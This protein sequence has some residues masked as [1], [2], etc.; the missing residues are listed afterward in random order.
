MIKSKN[1][2]GVTDIVLMLGIIICIATL[3]IGSYALITTY[4]ERQAKASQEYLAKDLVSIINT[5]QAAPESATWEYYT[6]RDVNGYPVIGSLEIDEANSELC[7]HPKSESE[8]FGSIVD[9]ASK[10]AGLGA[11]GYMYSKV[12]KA[13]LDRAD[14]RMLAQ[15][16]EIG[17]MFDRARPETEVLPGGP[18]GGADIFSELKTTPDGQRALW[19]LGDE[20][21]RGDA[22]RY[23]LITKEKNVG[24]KAMYFGDYGT[25]I[26]YMAKTPNGRS[27][28]RA[29]MKEAVSEMSDVEF[30]ESLIKKGRVPYPYEGY[31]IA[32]FGAGVE[33][34]SEDALKLLDEGRA[35]R[36]MFDELEGGSLKGVGKQE[37]GLMGKVTN[38]YYR[39]TLADNDVARMIGKL[40]GLA[41]GSEGLQTFL[42]PVT[43]APGIKEWIKRRIPCTEARK[44]MSEEAAATRAA[45]KNMGKPP[46]MLSRVGGALKVVIV[47]GVVARLS[48]GDYKQ[49]GYMAGMM[50]GPYVINYVDKLVFKKAVGDVTRK[51]VIAKSESKISK[52]K[53]KL[54]ASG[55]G[56]GGAVVIHLGEY[57]VNIIDAFYTMITTD[58]WLAMISDAG[59]KT[60]KKESALLHCESY[61]D[62]GQKVLL[63]PP[64]CVP[65]VRYGRPDFPGESRSLDQARQRVGE[66]PAIEEAGASAIKEGAA[67]LNAFGDPNSYNPFNKDNI[68][69]RI[70]RFF[71]SLANY[72]LKVIELVG[73]ALSNFMSNVTGAMM[74][75]IQ[76]NF[77][78]FADCYK[79]TNWH[80][81]QGF[82]SKALA[83][84][85]PAGANFE[86]LT[87]E[88]VDVAKLLGIDVVQG[89]GCDV[90]YMR[91]DCPNY[92]ISDKGDWVMI[93]GGAFLA[94]MN[95]GPYCAMLSAVEFAEPVCNIARYTGAFAIFYDSP[96]DIF[97][98]FLHAGDM[99][100]KKPS[101][102]MK[103]LDGSCGAG[104]IC[105]DPKKEPCFA[106]NKGY[107]YAEFPGTIEFNKIYLP[108]QQDASKRVRMVIS[109]G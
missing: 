23:A 19:Y 74:Q 62:T 57:A 32:T 15:Q 25:N 28:A 91:Q 92:F 73:S 108:D 4:L 6:E 43:K 7:I 96:A 105:C 69:V 72:A 44:A 27:E 101:V 50:L 89:T 86:D 48:G 60:V 1:K 49:I 36:N 5:L 102:G 84:K 11:M 34:G 76:G 22:I 58:L 66:P 13:Q 93:K 104:E 100:L 17:K 46:T 88:Q 77:I 16:K 99:G 53:S 51:V 98:F 8:M 10:A 54:A 79:D 109:K 3:M 14:K 94:L 20:S 107:W 81:K 26:R 9:S 29:L 47:F 87:K 38:S 71:A 83:S 41:A 37:Y 21:G 55:V 30:T 65:K 52:I 39:D 80:L 45:L 97:N 82:L 2:K 90:E 106:N 78:P 63:S 24:A 85:L 95:L 103:R 59:A 18:P 56:L 75:W 61:V 70:G 35:M 68:I 33:S 67:L 42:K 12:R 64:N 40:D 31:S